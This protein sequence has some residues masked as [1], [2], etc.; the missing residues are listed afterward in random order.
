MTTARRTHTAT[1]L[2]NGKVLIAGG[3]SASA[4][5]YDPSTGTFTA[6]GDMATARDSHRA[7]LL[8]NG[9]VLMVPGGGGPDY[10]N[11]ELYDPDTGTF[12]LT[13]R[14]RRDVS[15]SDATATLLTNGK[16]LV[17]VGRLRG[18]AKRGS[19]R[20][21]D[22]NIHRYREHDHAPGWAHGHAA[23]RWN[24]LNRR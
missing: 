12:S 22:R 21:L 20:P 3:Y 24:R 19:V 8:N 16:V 11:A 13:E 6:T 10:K 1:L 7:T 5:L 9:R 14:R 17:T 23:P 15:V 18:E 4:E 2:N